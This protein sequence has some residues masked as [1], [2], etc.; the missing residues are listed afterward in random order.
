MRRS[1]RG[2]RS[3]AAREQD[4]LHRSSLHSNDGS[5][6][7]EQALAAARDALED[8]DEELRRGGDSLPALVELSRGRRW[9]CRSGTDFTAWRYHRQRRQQNYRYKPLRNS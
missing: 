3:C 7:Q 5:R 9:R 1:W 4:R 2:G 6:V 8:I